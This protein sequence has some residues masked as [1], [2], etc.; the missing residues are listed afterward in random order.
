M[1][2]E[3]PP[4]IHVLTRYRD[5]NRSPCALAESRRVNFFDFGGGNNSIFCRREIW[6]EFCGELLDPQNR[7]S[8]IFG[9]ISEHFS[10][11]CHL[12]LLSR[13]F[14]PLAVQ[15]F[16]GHDCLNKLKNVS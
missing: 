6:G 9:E 16:W 10:Q 5:R 7:G 4:K 2:L 8:K 11:T 13:C 14:A 12:I 15:Y 3:G 1:F